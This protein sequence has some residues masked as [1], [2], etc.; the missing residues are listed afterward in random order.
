MNASTSRQVLQLYRNLMRYSKELK[1]TDQNYFRRRVR[2]EFNRN[3]N[4]QSEADIEFY[5]KVILYHLLTFI[6]IYID[7]KPINKLILQ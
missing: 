6:P 1:F 7:L 3:K 4:L 5:I 2:K